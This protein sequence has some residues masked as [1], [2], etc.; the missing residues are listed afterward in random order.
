MQIRYCKIIIIIVII[1]III[2]IIILIIII[3]SNNN[4]NNNNNNN[5]FYYTLS[6]WFSLLND[7][8]CWWPVGCTSISSSETGM[9]LLCDDGI[10]PPHLMS[11]VPFIWRTNKY[12]EK[13]NKKD[14][15]VNGP[16]I[17]WELPCKLL[18]CKSIQ[19]FAVSWKY[20]HVG[21]YYGLGKHGAHFHW[22]VEL[23]RW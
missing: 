9:L 10:C 3:N 20:F 4:N 14:L 21:R 6:S 8:P 19:S 1:I 7:C 23:T 12:Q 17:S 22:S 18:M 11:S 15:A 16:D 13:Q 2:I 5:K